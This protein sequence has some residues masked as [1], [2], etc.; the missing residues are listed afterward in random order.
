MGE[1]AVRMGVD[2]SRSRRARRW[3]VRDPAPTSRRP[4]HARPAARGVIF[5]HE[6]DELVMRGGARACDMHDMVALRA[7]VRPAPPS[8]PSS[9]LNGYADIVGDDY[10]LKRGQRMGID[11]FGQRLLTGRMAIAEA[12]L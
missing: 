10:V 8:R 2:R 1:V 4:A 9:L 5:A 3:R 6:F 12:A 11:V 7:G